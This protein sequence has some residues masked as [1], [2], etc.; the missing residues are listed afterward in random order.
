MKMSKTTL[1]FDVERLMKDVRE[2]VSLRI[3]IRESLETKPVSLRDIEALA[4][5]SAS[6]LSRMDNGAMPD[7]D[8]FMKLC[9][10]FHLNA[11]KYFVRIEWKGEIQVTES[12]T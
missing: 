12:E 8:T 2:I 7:M 11:G 1:E 6:T 10:V 3:A 9:H 4:G 5:I